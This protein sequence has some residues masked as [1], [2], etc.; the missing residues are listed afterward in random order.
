[1]RS[2]YRKYALVVAGLLVANFCHPCSAQFGFQQRSVGGVAID[3]DGVLSAPTVQDEQDLSAI[4]KQ[5]RVAVPAE[6]EQF[7]EL[8]AVS[9]RQLEAEIAK[10]QADKTPLAESVLFLAGLQRVEYVIVYPE[11]NDIVLAGPAEGWKIDKLGNLVG[12]TTNRPVLLLDDLLIALRSGPASRVESIT[13]SIDPTPEGLQRWQAMARSM[14]NIGDPEQTMRRI[15]EALGPQT[16]S[17]TGISSNTHF[18]RAMVA[19]DFRM[20]RLAMNFEPAPVGGMP[21]FLEMLKAGSAGASSMMPRWWLAPNYQPLGQTADG[22]TWQLRGPGVQCMTEQ[23]FIDASGKKLH[24][25]KAHPIAQKWADSMTAKFG[26]LATHDSAFGQLRNV[27]DLAVIGALIE[28]HQLFEQAGLET[29]YLMAN[30]E[31]AHF[32]TPRQTSSKASFVKKGKKWLISASGGVEILP[33]EIAD[34]SETV[35]SIG[36]V[37]DSLATTTGQLSWE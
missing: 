10:A 4:R 23:D 3:V 13:C 15:E 25:G 27:M 9:L 11:R 31:P 7:T 28:K 26:E 34:V 36:K 14:R 29:P 6:L 33:W 16:I 21:S 30:L 37:R 20:K 35:E 24:S 1:M 5:A 18:A 19:A 8:R 17:V 32:P 2:L 22:L 12:S